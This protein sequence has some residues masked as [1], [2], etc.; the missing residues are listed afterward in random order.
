[1]M[2]FFSEIVN[3]WKNLLEN[4]Y[5]FDRVLDTHLIYSEVTLSTTRPLY[6]F[7]KQYLVIIMKVFLYVCCISNICFLKNC[8]WVFKECHKWFWKSIFSYCFLWSIYFFLLQSLLLPRQWENLPF[9]LLI[10]L[11]ETCPMIKSRQREPFPIHFFNILN[12]FGQ[13]VVPWLI[14]KPK[15]IRMH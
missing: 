15:W 1:M 10:W 5:M 4:S 7:T 3:G 6:Y 9:E 14:F 11:H 2:E 13:I 12:N 8:I